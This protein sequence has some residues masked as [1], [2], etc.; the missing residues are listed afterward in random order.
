MSVKLLVV[1]LPLQLSVQSTLV[2]TAVGIPFISDPTGLQPR[3]NPVVGQVNT[4]GVLS[5][6]ATDLVQVELQPFTSVTLRVRI[7]EALQVAPAVT[8]TF[9]LVVLPMILPFP[10]ILQ[11]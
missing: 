1:P 4:G 8:V 5:I 10:E 2:T 6:T 3:F 11:R 9:W 7:N